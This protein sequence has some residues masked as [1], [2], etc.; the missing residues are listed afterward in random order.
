MNTKC[1]CKTSLCTTGPV[2]CWEAWKQNVACLHDLWL[3]TW[4]KTSWD[5]KDGEGQSSSVSSKNLYLQTLSQQWLIRSSPEI[6]RWDS[7]KEMEQTVSVSKCVYFCTKHLFCVHKNLFF[8]IIIFVLSVHTVR[9]LIMLIL[10]EKLQTESFFQLV[11][12]QLWRKGE[13]F[14]QAALKNYRRRQRR[15]WSYCDLLN[16]LAWML[17]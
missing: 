3:V 14:L 6:W 2:I 15:R 17:Q 5:G 9:L 7:F 8:L 13:R 4:P 1:R 12:F 10:L 16:R 11:S